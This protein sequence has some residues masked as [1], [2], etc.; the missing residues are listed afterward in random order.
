MAFEQINSE[1][2][3]HCKERPELGMKTKS[4]AQALVNAIPSDETLRYWICG[5]SVF[6]VTAE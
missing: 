2:L 5:T 4:E 1:P 3:Y 6:S